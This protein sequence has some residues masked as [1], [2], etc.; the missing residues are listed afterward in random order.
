[1]VDEVDPDALQSRRVL[2]LC[3]MWLN[4]VGTNV[5]VTLGVLNQW[6]P[7]QHLEEKRRGK[8]R[9]KARKRFGQ[10]PNKFK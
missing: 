9:E 10:K 6:K 4:N 5:K 8:N 3:R 2:Y 1:M 7:D